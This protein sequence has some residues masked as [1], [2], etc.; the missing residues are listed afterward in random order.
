VLTFEKFLNG[1]GIKREV[2]K[3]GGREIVEIWRETGQGKDYH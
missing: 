1:K 2:M 3:R